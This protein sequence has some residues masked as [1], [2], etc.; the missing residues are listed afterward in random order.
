MK[1]LR[2]SASQV[3]DFR[4]CKRLWVFRSVLKIRSPQTPAQARGTVIHAALEAY[5]QNGELSPALLKQAEERE[6]S[7]EEL[8]GYVDAIKPYYGNPGEG[9]TEFKDYIPTYPGGPMFTVVVDHAR[10]MVVDG[11]EYPQIDDLKTTSDFRYAK[12]PAQL[13][14]DV[15]MVSYGKWACETAAEQSL[16]P[17]DFVTLR[18]VYALTKGAKKKTMAREVKVTPTQ[19]DVQWQGVLDDVRSMVALAEASTEAPDPQTVEPNTASCS[20]YG[21]CF[22]RTTC[23]GNA[24][25][26]TIFTK[27][28]S[29]GRLAD[30]MKELTNGLPAAPGQ[31]ALPPVARCA[32]TSQLLP[33]IVCGLPPHTGNH[34]SVNAGGGAVNWNDTAVMLGNSKDWKPLAA[35]T[36]QPALAQ[37]GQV[38]QVVP[39]DAPPRETELT[40]PST[41]APPVEAP[42]KRGRKSLADKAA[43]AAAAASVPIVQSQSPSSGIVEV[44]SG[45]QG[46]PTIS[47]VAVVPSVGV[48]KACP[49][50]ELYI[51]CFPVK[52]HAGGD[53]GL[54]EDII[55]GLSLGAAEAAGVPDWRLIEFGKGKGAV[56]AILR[57]RLNTVPRVLVVSSSTPGSDVLLEVLTPHAR[58]VV[59]AL[60]G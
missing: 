30:R 25:L 12:T 1:L 2:V 40:A 56:A 26:S 59:R 48:S 28:K 3:K 33:G 37:I 46:V 10:D 18:H 60:R 21:G 17:P 16:A 57:E 58:R 4:M 43:E 49:L 36:A 14:E 20:A 50:E 38:A 22:F 55:A 54:A 45:Q 5:L 35:Q 47:S 53:P 15:Q 41:E 19:I 32:G 23:F 52:G 24:T 11:K 6:I 34:E 8:R 13:A 9:L 29:M 44:K 39:P 31:T 42:K 51:D 7:E 27:E